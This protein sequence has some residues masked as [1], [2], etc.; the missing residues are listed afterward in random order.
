M[1]VLGPGRVDQRIRAA[2][3]ALKATGEG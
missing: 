2:I 3:D 1:L